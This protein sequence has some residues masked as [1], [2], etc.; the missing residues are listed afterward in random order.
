M[1]CTRMKYTAPTAAMKI[2][3]VQRTG[4]SFSQFQWKF[5]A[6]SVWFGVGLLCTRGQAS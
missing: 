2:A 5:N 4:L 1:R 3:T 6:L